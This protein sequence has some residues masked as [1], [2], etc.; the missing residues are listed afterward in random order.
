MFIIIHK[1]IFIGIST[2]L[3]ILSLVLLFV[4]GLKPGIDFTGGALLEV[5]YTGDR[6]AVADIKTDA[7]IQP[8]GE[9]GYIVKTHDLTEAEHAELL[10]SLSLDGKNPL[11]ETN[12]NS[13]GPSVGRE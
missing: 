1:K 3:V 4:W 8:T 6:P 13:I 12:F 9:K 10:T 2:L 11:T 7:L 5:T